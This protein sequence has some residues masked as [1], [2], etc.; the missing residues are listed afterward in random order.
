MQIIAAAGAIDSSHVVGEIGE[1]LTNQVA[2]RTTEEQITVY[3]SVGVVAQDLAAAH[4]V[5]LR[6]AERE[7][8]NVRAI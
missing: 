5:Y 4:A 2:G 1:V 3:K 8:A 6:G 7:S